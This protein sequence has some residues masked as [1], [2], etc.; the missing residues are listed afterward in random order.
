MFTLTNDNNNLNRKNQSENKSLIKNGSAIR[1]LNNMVY[2]VNNE[3]WIKVLKLFF[4]G[5]NVTLHIREVAR[6]A[7]LTP[8]GAKYILDSLKNDGLLNNESGNIVNNFWGNYD[9]EKFIGLK[10]SLNL[11][12]LYSSGLTSELE[13]FYNVPKCIV[14]FGSYVKGEDTSKSDIDI[15]VVTDMED[16]PELSKYEVI[17]NR[18]ININ[19]IKNVKK[20]DANFINS[21]ANG[22]VLSGY[23]EVI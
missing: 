17:L 15:A 11:N 12:S 19:L 23:L 8:R 5:P 10:R 1:N 3:N 14:L 13:N 2:D 9:S 22:I 20:E 21:M 7:N 6:R 16:I 4:D 18:K